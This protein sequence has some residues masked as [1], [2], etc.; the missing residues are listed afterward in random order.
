MTHKKKTKETE[1]GRRNVACLA[2]IKNNDKQIILEDNHNF[3]LFCSL[4]KK[5]KKRKKTQSVTNEVFNFF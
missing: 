1:K 3:F 4:N 2:K 5:K